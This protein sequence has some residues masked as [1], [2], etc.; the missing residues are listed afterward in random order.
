[1]KPAKARTINVADQSPPEASVSSPH[2]QSRWARV[3]PLLVLAAF[4]LAALLALALAEEED[5]EAISPHGKFLQDCTLCH[6]AEAWKPILAEPL[7]DHAE[8][9]FPLE[10]AHG[11]VTCRTCHVSLDFTEAEADCVSCHQDVHR[12]ELGTDCARCH[13]TRHFI[14]RAK[15]TRA[16]RLTRFP[17]TGT[18][19]ALDCNECHRPAGSGQ[20]VFVNTPAE[21]ETC[22]LER[23]R[24]TTDPDH[25]ALGFPTDCEQCH[26]TFGWD[27]S[28]FNHGVTGFDLKGSHASLDCDACH[29]GNDIRGASPDCVSCH[30]QDY[31]RTTNPNH[32]AAGFPTDCALCH[33]TVS[34]RPADFRHGRY[35][36]IDSGAHRG[37]WSDCSDC[38][39]NASNFADFSCLT[40]HPHSDR[41]QTDRDH[42]GRS[43][44]SY[45]SRACY[46]CHPRG[47]E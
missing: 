32:L 28:R 38:H 35:F 44:Y 27:H 1:M 5:L 3:F 7:L 42:G 10:G 33:R 47:E 36:P 30:Q 2:S 26:S 45:D 31:D 40:C 4:L 18:H 29:A 6:S 34:W 20:M 16:H 11:V 9:G 22:H 19:V 37:K 23:Y 17:L 14:E 12:G 25:E 24:S 13:T 21:C 15:M 43:G 41:T 8:T 46:A 39:I